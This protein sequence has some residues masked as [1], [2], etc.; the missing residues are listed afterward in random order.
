MKTSRINW[1]WGKG[2]RNF[3]FRWVLWDE[4]SVKGCKKII[5]VPDQ[6]NLENFLSVD[7]NS[8]EHS[9]VTDDDIIL[10]TKNALIQQGDEYSDDHVDITD[11][12][13]VTASYS[14]LM[15]RENAY[16]CF[17]SKNVPKEIFYYIHP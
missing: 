15:L 8:H 5:L 6:V 11:E 2:I 14:S 16:F 12:S 3:R 10:S 17:S 7:Y 9:E 13:K 4:N 1:D